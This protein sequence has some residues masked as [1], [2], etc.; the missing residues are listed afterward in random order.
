MYAFEFADGSSIAWERDVPQ[1]GLD[2]FG[3][4]DE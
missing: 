2:N 3:H 1:A 4:L